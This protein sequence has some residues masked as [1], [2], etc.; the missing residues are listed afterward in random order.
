MTA[1]NSSEYKGIWVF[2]EQ[3]DGVIANVTFELL[4]KCREFADK[5]GQKLSAVLI[6]ENLEDTAHELIYFG[7]DEVI[8][9]DSPVFF[10]YRTNPYTDILVELVNEYKPS[11][12]IYGATSVGRDLAPRVAA[13]LKTGLTA[14]CLDL[15]VDDNGLLIQTKPS[16]G[17]N[18]MCK[19][20]CPN[21]RPQMTTVRPKVFPMPERD[22]SRTGEIIRKKVNIKEED[23]PFKIIETFKEELKGPKIEEA[24]VIVAGGRGLE[25]KE[26]LKLI[27]ELADVLGG[28]IGV[29]RPLVDEGWLPPYYQIGQSGKT[30]KPK[31]II[32]CG[33]SGAVQFTVGMQSA[34]VIVAIDKNPDA[35]I[36][37]VATYG[38][39]GRVEEILPELIKKFKVMLNK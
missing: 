24:D 12:I 17:G 39:V 18:I 32:T 10:K 29:T 30:V 7:A 38:I 35:A 11:M 14:D 25:T 16:Y 22:S 13:R 31:L 28:T 26:N 15:E 9:A 36:F 21:H 5:L 19:I 23:I 8:L 27:K 34:D 37:N 3:R 2:A 1:T 4:G 20:I 33:V 6:G